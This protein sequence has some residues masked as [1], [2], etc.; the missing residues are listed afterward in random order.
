MPKLT[1]EMFES[2]PEIG[3]EVTVKGIVQTIDDDGNVGISYDEVASVP[4]EEVEEVEDDEGM[5]GEMDVEKSFRK[6]QKDQK[7]GE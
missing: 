5:D 2:P 3:Q 6:F 7:M 1:L 4:M